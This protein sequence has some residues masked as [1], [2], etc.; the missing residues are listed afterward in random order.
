MDIEEQKAQLLAI[1]EETRKE[2]EILELKYQILER[3]IT[4]FSSPIWDL[5]RSLRI[6]FSHLRRFEEILK[7]TFMPHI[8]THSRLN[9]RAEAEETIDL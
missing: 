6:K 8:I 5:E 7:G 4:E 9:N 3:L 2:V 1:V